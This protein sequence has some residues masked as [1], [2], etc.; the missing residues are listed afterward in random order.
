LNEQQYHIDRQRRTSRLLH[1]SGILEGLDVTLENDI[2]RISRGA[3]IDPG[4]QQILLNSAAVYQNATIALTQNGFE[5]NLANL[6]KTISYG[7]LLS[8][9]EVDAD[10]Q[11]DGG[12]PENTR[13]YELP[14][15]T[16]EEISAT[17]LDSVLL[18]MLRSNDNINFY[19]DQSQRQYAGLKLPATNGNGVTLRSENGWSPLAVLTG[20]LS[21]TESVNVTSRLF[22]GDGM[23]VSGGL[24][25]SDGLVVTGGLGV[26]D[27]LFVT[28]GLSVS[29]G[30]VGIGTT[31]P[32][33][34]KLQIEGGISYT[35]SGGYRYLN[36]GGEGQTSG[37]AMT[38]SVYAD[39]AL[40]GS[41][42]NAFSDA[43]IKQVRGTSDSH[44]DLQTLLKIEVKDYTYKDSH[45]YDE[46]L[47]KKVIGQQVAQVYPNAIRKHI[48]FV[49][50]IFK[51]ASIEA[52]WVTLPQHGLKPEER[53]KIFTNGSESHIC[54]VEA[55]EGDRFK[56]PLSVS[57]E[58]FIYG[59]EVDDFHV[60]DYD[61]LS[62]LNISATQALYKIIET[63]QTEVQQLK[64]QIKS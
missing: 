37:N 3:A 20:S 54:T 45:A 12:K 13:V 57:G 27:G 60:V 21:V 2:L 53:V 44:L 30:N 29:D 40:G 43:R 25:V 35:Q 48:E 7:L 23:S 14:K 59:R 49:P 55:V 24:N 34:G 62:M 15:L 1:V 63:L 19:L 52:D 5:I 17:P 39:N 58:V 28:G 11:M 9:V 10:P 64:A 41:E 32:D 46:R 47:Y 33:R 36:R 51:P 38:Y 16:L 56:V 31:S 22:V 26:S 8:G 42:F 6:D 50:D 18:A 4:G 61:A